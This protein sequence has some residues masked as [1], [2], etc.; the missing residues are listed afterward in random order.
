M[1]TAAEDQKFYDLTI[2]T[3]LHRTLPS[4]WMQDNPQHF[5]RD[6]TQLRAHKL[7][8]ASQTSYFEGL[9]RQENPDQVAKTNINWLKL[10]N[11]ER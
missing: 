10:T 4:L 6:G 5:F 8:L 2:K 9:F 7:V 11:K 3:R 1:A